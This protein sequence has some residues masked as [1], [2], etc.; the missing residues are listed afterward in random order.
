MHD[1]DTDKVSTIFHFWSEF[2][3]NVCLCFFIFLFR[4]WEHSDLFLHKIAGWKNKLYRICCNDEGCN[5]LEKSIKA[6]LVGEVYQ[7]K[8]ETD[9]G[10]VNKI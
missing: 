6:V 1:V 8:S 2:S 9:E 4:I 3:M 7:S 10:G 5:I